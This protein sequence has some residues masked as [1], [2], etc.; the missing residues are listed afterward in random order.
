MNTDQL[1]SDSRPFLDW[2]VN[3]YNERPPVELT[4]ILQ[5]VENDP[6]RVAVL[7]VDVTTGFCSEG[8]LSSPR[9]GRIVDPIARLFQRAYDLGVRHF[10]LPQ[11]THTEDAVEFGSYP[12]HCVRGTDEPVTVPELRNLPFAD[13]FTTIEKNSISSDIDT[14]LD[15]WLD[16]HPEVST[17]IVVGDCTDIC[18]YQLAMH[19]RLRANALNLREV[20]V[21]L[22]VDGVDTFDIPVDVAEE[23]G[24]M[25]HHGDLIH[26]IFLYSMAEN[27]VEIVAEVI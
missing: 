24:A 1:I 3:W 14:E 16:S 21:L 23:I 27:G 5:G 20:R 8:P 17:L 18:V 4:R 6:S 25:P 7:A 26:L 22:P 12:A 15:D 10:L 9:V 2:L 13:L 11:D 19:L